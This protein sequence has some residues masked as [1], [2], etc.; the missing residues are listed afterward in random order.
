MTTRIKITGRASASAEGKRL[1]VDWRKATPFK[2]PIPRNEKRRV[3][4]LRGHQI[5]DTLP[6]ESFDAIT[7]L[8]AHIC[9]TPIALLT[10]V[11][12][13]RQWFKSKVGITISETSRDVAFCAHAIMQREL[14]VVR[15]ASADKRFAA[16]PLVT[17]DPKIRFYAGAPL[18]TAQNHALGTLCVLDRVPRILTREQTD[19]LR[20]LSRH[21]LAQMEMRREI[22]ELK[23][24]F[25][26]Q[27]AGLGESEEALERARRTQSEYLLKISHEIRAT[28]KGVLGVADQALVTE[29][30]FRQRNYLKNIKSSA[31]YLLTLAKEIAGASAKEIR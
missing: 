31:S 8:A 9:Q 28:T 24:H 27:Q 5:L 1:K 3:A 18:V 20:A 10:L 13:D 30:T 21:V 7:L 11:D 23:K 29:L 26:R 14:F 6:E 22:M 4:E 25:L 2:V 16:N 17:S 19:A 12:S 15:D